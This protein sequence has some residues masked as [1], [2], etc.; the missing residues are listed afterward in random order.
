M[1]RHE[2]SGNS[3]ELT[4]SA[5][6]D[7]IQ[8]FFYLFYKIIWLCHIYTHSSLIIP[9]FPWW[10]HNLR[11]VNTVHE[12]HEERLQPHW[13]ACL[14]TRNK[15]LLLVGGAHNCSSSSLLPLI[16]LN[17]DLRRITAAIV[18]QTVTKSLTFNRWSITYCI[19]CIHIVALGKKNKQV[20]HSNGTD[21]ALLYLKFSFSTY[22]LLKQ[23]K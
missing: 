9:T 15:H 12:T 3:W 6:A 19:V 17:K 4:P 14:H 23:H 7:V 18:N 21:L 13:M 1:K 10:S 2:Q 11:P 22:F 16:I 5:Q 20:F 8:F